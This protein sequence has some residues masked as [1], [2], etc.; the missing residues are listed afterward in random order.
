MLGMEN[1]CATLTF[2]PFFWCE[3]SKNSVDE[4][5]TNTKIRFRPSKFISEIQ[6]EDQQNEGELFHV[7]LFQS[8]L[9]QNFVNLPRWIVALNE[10]PITS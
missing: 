6:S 5:R 7:R 10:T 4:Q 8:L 3:F 2:A 9:C 1:F